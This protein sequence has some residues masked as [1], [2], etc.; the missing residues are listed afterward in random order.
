VTDPPGLA[1]RPDGVDAGGGATTTAGAGM[2]GGEEMAPVTTPIQ[3]S[4]SRQPS[5]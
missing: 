1:A 2:G 3:G 5:A 4:L